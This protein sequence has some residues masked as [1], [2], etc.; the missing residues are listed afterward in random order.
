MQKYRKKEKKA[1]NMFNWI[2]RRQKRNNMILNDW[3]NVR[4]W[5]RK[6]SAFEKLDYSFLKNLKKIRCGVIKYWRTS[7][8]DGGDP[9]WIE[10]MFGNIVCPFCLPKFNFPF[11]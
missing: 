5:Q 4:R 7:I 10:T 8:R 6:Q 2:P 9:G 3:A 1:D 11:S